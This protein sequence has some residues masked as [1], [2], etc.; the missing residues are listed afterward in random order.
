MHES[1]SGVS[2]MYMNWFTEN[3]V[4][5]NAVEVPKVRWRT[6]DEPL[7]QGLGKDENVAHVN[8]IC[9]YVAGSDLS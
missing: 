7:E 4:H 3:G 5:V 6:H 8:A 2:L 9:V 1:A